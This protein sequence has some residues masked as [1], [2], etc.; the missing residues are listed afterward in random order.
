MYIYHMSIYIIFR[1][2][3]QIA[4]SA[5]CIISFV[6]YIYHMLLPCE[7]QEYI[8]CWNFKDN[9]YNLDNEGVK[10]LLI[11]YIY[12]MSICIIF[13][14]ELQIAII[15]LC[16][17]SFIMYIYHICG[18]RSFFVLKL[19]TQV[20]QYVK[21]NSD[22]QWVCHVHFRHGNKLYL[23]VWKIF[24]VFCTVFYKT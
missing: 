15:A 3:I 19:Q 5:I 13:R 11:M 22:S 20:V 7:S 21:W 24:R 16:I 9:Y 12:H 14:V 4:T 1:I 6:M 17:I 18:Y 2:E 8:L 10:Y 23:L